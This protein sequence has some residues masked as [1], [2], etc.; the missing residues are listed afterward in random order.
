[1]PTF[2]NTPTPQLD[3]PGYHTNLPNAAYHAGPGVSKSQL[4]LLHHAPALLQW[5]RSAPRDEE[6][7]AAVDVGDAF[8]ATSL[9]PHRFDAEYVGDFVPPADALVTVDQVKAYMDDNG[10]GYSAK[11][12]KGT[13]V[14]KLLDMEPDAPV[15]DR[16]RGDW[17][18]ALGGRRVLT[19]PEMKKLNLMR[20]SALAHPFARRLLEA[21]GDVE[22]SIY[23]IDPETGVLCRCR[24]DKLVRLGDMRIL[25]DVKTTAEIDRFAASIEE[26]RYYVQDPFYTEGYTQHFGAPPDAFV[27]LVV[28]TTRSAGRYPVHCF[29]LKPEDKLAGR[30]EFQ[31]DLR[32]YAE[33][34]RTGVWGG[35]ET[36]TRP[37]WARRAAA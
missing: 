24:P 5:V 18:A 29:S 7:R 31:A 4:D 32:T 21:D 16:L 22:P 6:A 2:M 25:L 23:W 17:E 14:A 11:D 26:Y 12:S 13:L 37:A 1:M 27:F 15:L 36:I 8:H 35:I 19:A 9:E 20:E 3:R 30:N 34:Q 28:S 33:C 10:I